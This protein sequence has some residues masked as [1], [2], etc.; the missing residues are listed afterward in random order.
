ME[1]NVVPVIYIPNRNYKILNLQYYFHT[2][3]FAKKLKTKKIIIISK[4]NIS[5]KSKRIIVFKINKQLNFK[6]KV[7]YT[8]LKKIGKRNKLSLSKII[9]FN[10]I[11]P[12]RDFKEVLNA[13][14][15][16]NIKN[17]SNLISVS[18]SPE[19]P[20]KM[21]FFSNDRLKNVLEH[22]SIS[23]SHSVPRQ[24]LP[25]TFIENGGYEIINLKRKKNKIDIMISNIPPISI[26][27][28][29]DAYINSIFKIIN[30]KGKIKFTKD[31]L[32]S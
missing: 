22:K 29:N 6:K 20:Y 10:S 25:N 14:K 28:S 5:L 7:L 27:D 12:L 13:I 4:K 23:D 2:I 16:F 24:I 21:W 31:K 17:F 1:N 26:D 19:N 18:V 32:P 9:F 15:N 3:N 11:Y 30:K 8:I